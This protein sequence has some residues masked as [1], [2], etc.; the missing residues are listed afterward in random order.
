MILNGILGYPLK[1]P[2][3]IKIWKKYFKENKINARM[4]KFEIFSK[5]LKNF[6]SNIKM[7]K[8]FK[9][10][11]VTMP[12]KKTVIKYLDSLDNISQKAQSVNLVVK[13]KNKLV[14]FN[15]DVFGAMNTLKIF[16]NKYDQ[17]IIIGLGGTGQAIFNYLVSKYKKKKFYLI[18][19]KFNIKKRQKKKITIRRFINK[20][21]I[22]S[23]A[24]IVNCTPLGS[25][26]KKNYIN[27]LPIKKNT[28]HFINKKSVIFDVI[29]S[30]KK[31][32]LSKYCSKKK[33]K[34]INGVKMN[35]LQ[36]Q[37]AL[38]ITFSSK[39]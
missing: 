11:A 1:R 29:Y 25:N 15:T 2:R 20:E 13:K 16:L 17:I 19:T 7:N 5:D 34:Y 22:S 31:T 4:L 32:L 36:A 35:T 24:L 18:S 3:S 14:G 28:L 27:K 12:Y 21:L 26:L 23:C 37:K 30:P 38:Q 39:I 6:F 8:N 10:M 9:A 33:I